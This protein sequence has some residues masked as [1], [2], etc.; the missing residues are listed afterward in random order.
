M[1]YLAELKNKVSP[2][3]YV[4]QGLDKL[5]KLPEFTAALYREVQARNLAIKD[6]M[7]C[8]D[9]LYR[10]VYDQMK[11]NDDIFINIIYVRPTQFSENERA[12]IVTF[13]KVQDNW[14]NPIYWRENI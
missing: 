9:N 7:A 14:I 1:V 5:A 2:S 6:V 10:K 3:I 8:V 13:L 12:A 11:G 4:Q